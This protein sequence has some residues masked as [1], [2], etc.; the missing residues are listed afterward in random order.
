M[1]EIRCQILYTK[2][3]SHQ[4]GTIF[5]VAQDLKALLNE[6]KMVYGSGDKEE[7]RRD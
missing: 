4:V 3:C 6:R 2:Y 1:L 5:L 7:L